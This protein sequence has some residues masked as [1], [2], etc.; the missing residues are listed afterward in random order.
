MRNPIIR[1]WKLRGI[2]FGAI[3]IYMALHLAY[4]GKY[5]APSTTGQDFSTDEFEEGYIL[6]G[7]ICDR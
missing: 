4:A 5:P 3:G 7:D 6:Y 2:L 1:N